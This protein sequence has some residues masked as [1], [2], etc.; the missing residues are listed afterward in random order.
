MNKEEKL[1]HVH[2]KL[3]FME[4]AFCAADPEDGDAFI[5]NMKIVKE[6]IDEALKIIE[7]GGKPE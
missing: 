4:H 6:T 7:T 3:K 2:A 5:S 1:S